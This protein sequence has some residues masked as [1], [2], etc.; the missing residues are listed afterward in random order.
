MPLGMPGGFEPLHPILALARGAMRVFAP[1]IEVATLAMLH[2]GQE[3]PLHHAVAPELIGDH[4]AW[5]VWQPFEQLAK[6]LLRG[7]LVAAALYQDV[8]DVVVLIDGAPE[9]MTFTI[10]GEKHLIEVPL[11]PWLSASTLQLIRVVL[12]KFLT[13]LADGFM[14]DDDPALEQELLHIAIAQGKAVVEPDA[15]ANDL[16]GEAV[17]F[18]AYG[19]SGW[20]HVWLPI[21]V[22]AW[23]VRNITGVSIAWVR[24]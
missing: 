18:V 14:G 3:L 13:P 9:V 10:D 12:P 1:V 23:F 19:V 8:E 7:L 20:R 21:G 2:P 5:Y 16:T 11:I 4:H 22:F 17:V 24:Q 15:M 6:E